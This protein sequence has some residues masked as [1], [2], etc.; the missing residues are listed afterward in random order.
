MSGWRG[1]WLMAI[2]LVAGGAVSGTA[3]NG[4]NATITLPT[5]AENDVVFVAGAHP[6]KESDAG[7]STA[8]YTE[9]ADVSHPTATPSSRLSVN[10]K[11]MGP[12]PDATAVVL[13]SGNNADG[14]VGAALCLRGVDPFYIL[15][16]V[17]TTATGT[18]T[19]PDPPA[20]V[21]ATPGAWVLAFASSLTLDAAI[22]A[23]TSYINLATNTANDSNDQTIAGCTREIASPGSENPASYTLWTTG[24]VWIAITVAV[25]PRLTDVAVYNLLGDQQWPYPQRARPEVV[26]SGMTPPSRI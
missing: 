6:R 7:M 12:S 13:G 3:I 21:T 17:V 8:G 24:S 11:V 15:D 4:L 19:N 5:L 2:T 20:I 14:T 1:V 18:T 16:A 26:A 22:T 9:I 23:P 10:Y 25:R